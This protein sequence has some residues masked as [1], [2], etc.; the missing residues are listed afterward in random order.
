MQLKQSCQPEPLQCTSYAAGTHHILVIN[1]DDNFCISV[2]WQ[3]VCVNKDFTAITWILLSVFKCHPDVEDHSGKHL[4]NVNRSRAVNVH[5]VSIHNPFCP[6]PPD[7]LQ[8]VRRCPVHKR[9]P[10]LSRT[11]AK[12]QDGAMIVA[13]S[14]AICMLALSKCYVHNTCDLLWMHRNKK[15]DT[16]FC[17]CPIFPQVPA[18][19]CL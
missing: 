1:G 17:K 16:D 10:A 11:S 3:P 5:M 18:T 13:L 12:L 6:P 14:K 9:G 2:Q 15:K 19:T 4:P 8:V 7:G